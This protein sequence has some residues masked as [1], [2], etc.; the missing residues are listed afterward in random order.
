MNQ[1]SEGKTFEKLPQDIYEGWHSSIRAYLPVDR[2]NFQQ[3]LL[4]ARDREYAVCRIKPKLLQNIRDS[5]ESP[6][7]FVCDELNVPY[8]GHLSGCKKRLQKKT[9]EG[10]EYICLCTTNKGYQGYKAKILEAIDEEEEK[11]I[12]K[13][14]PVS[15]GITFA[16]TMEGGPKYEID[17][18]TPSNLFGKMILLI[19]SCS[20]YLRY[21]GSCLITDSAY[22]YLSG[23][24]FLQLWSVLW[25]TSFRFAL[26]R[27]FRGI[28]DIKNV[29]LAKLSKDEKKDAQLSNAKLL[30][31]KKKENHFN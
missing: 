6:S 28:E 22:G 8:T 7:T 4:G 18:T 1:T 24:V 15:G 9:R 14:D 27:G 5:R 19:F 25:V 10:L 31:G 17:Q 26:R 13:A 16:Y 12:R 2:E 21:Q 29:Y 11:V 30:K 23:M 3:S 20:S